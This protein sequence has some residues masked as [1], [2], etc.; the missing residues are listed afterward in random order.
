LLSREAALQQ[1]HTEQLSD[2]VNGRH[3]RDRLRLVIA[4]LRIRLPREKAPPDRSRNCEAD[5]EGFAEN[6]AAEIYKALRLD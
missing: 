4:I 2:N 3:L 6:L 1:Q 5:A